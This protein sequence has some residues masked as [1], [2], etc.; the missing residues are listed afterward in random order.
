MTRGEI[1]YSKMN[2]NVWRMILV[3][4]NNRKPL[5]GNNKCAYNTRL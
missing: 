2:K 5:R 3:T 4:H 1:W